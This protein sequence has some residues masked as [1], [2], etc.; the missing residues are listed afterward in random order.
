M[1]KNKQIKEAK[2]QRKMFLYQEGDKEL[3]LDR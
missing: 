2:L 3:H 1:T